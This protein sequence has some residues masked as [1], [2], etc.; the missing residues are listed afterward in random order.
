MRA[1]SCRVAAHETDSLDDCVGGVGG[2]LEEVQEESVFGQGRIDVSNPSK[3]PAKTE[4]QIRRSF[5]ETKA[6][7]EAGDAEAQIDLGVMYE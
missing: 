1:V 3:P 2:V 7:A 5:A 6:K 4:A